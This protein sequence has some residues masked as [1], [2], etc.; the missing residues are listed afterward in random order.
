ME[1]EFD[2]E[3]DA[4]IRKERAARTIT[5][6]E[7]AGL[8]PDADE[9]AAFLENAVPATA[10]REMI[11]HFAGCDP[12]RRTLSN[13]V[14]LNGETV[15]T[16]PDGLAAPVEAAVVP[17]Y[18]RLFLF[19]NLAYLMGGLIILFGGF[20]GLSVFNSYQ[21][22][23]SDVSQMRRG[24][25]PAVQS[26]ATEEAPA[27]NNGMFENANVASMPANASNSSAG[28]TDTVSNSAMT[29]A[30]P[31]RST[32]N[33]AANTAAGKDK[34]FAIDGVSAPPPKPAR[35]QAA[36]NEPK[37]DDKLNEV[38]DRDRKATATTE[39]ESK[40]EEQSLMA[41]SAPAP[42]SGP[43]KMK[44]LMRSDPR[45]SRAAEADVTG[46][47]VDDQPAAGRAFDPNRKQVRGKT[48]EFREGAWFD[49]T[50]RGQGTTN[51]RRHTPDYSKLDLGLRGIAESLFGTVVTVWNG[52]AYRIY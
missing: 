22:S 35:A 42:S 39:K 45:D 29:N 15:S 49:T 8:H 13:A 10:R 18:R 7:F 11:G 26:P 43:M 24:A 14:V 25:A 38:A 6:G 36:K 1:L 23:A 37:A 32:A 50:Y 3:I 20:I 28:A 48:F 41:K 2:K 27:G 30:A 19:P 40:R 31:S 12:C 21:N 16:A 5:I 17:W 52:K 9:I 33:T 46:R 51:V 47:K 44:G 34:N 4:L